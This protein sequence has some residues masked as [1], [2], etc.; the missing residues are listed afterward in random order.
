[1]S[2]NTYSASIGKLNGIEPGI[3]MKIENQK[4]IAAN[5]RAISELQ[6]KGS[7]K[8]TPRARGSNKG[9]GGNNSK[10]YRD[11]STCGKRHPGE[12]HL[13]ANG[14]GNCRDNKRGEFFTKIDAQQYMKSM[15]AK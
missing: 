15:F 12:C 14:R 13:L 11:C 6:E 4:I 10:H 7:S 5:T 9:D 1:M 8:R 2:E 3:K